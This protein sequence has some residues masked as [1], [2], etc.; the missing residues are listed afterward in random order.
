M[1]HVRRVAACCN[2]F[3]KA[4][5]H[6]AICRIRLSFWR[7]TTS[8]DFLLIRRCRI[9]KHDI[10]TRVYSITYARVRIVYDK[11]YRVDSKTRFPLGDFFHANE[12]KAN[13]IGWWCRQRISPANQVGF[14]LCSRGQVRLVE[15]RLNIFR[16]RLWEHTRCTA[17][18]Q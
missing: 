2:L 9:L 1:H 15:N 7:M 18:P 5:L 3:I 8:A 10:Y 17:H 12:Q 14:F 13:V 11:S 6:D 4:Y 16:L